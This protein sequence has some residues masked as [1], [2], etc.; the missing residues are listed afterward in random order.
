MGEVGILM[1]WVVVYLE[2]INDVVY[3]VY[4]LDKE[5]SG[6]MIVVKNLVVVLILD[7]LISIGEIYCDYLVLVV[8]VLNLV[9]GIWDFF[10]G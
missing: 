5:I 4:C 3:M 2:G 9:C 7:W 6:V 1:N 10:L 8:G